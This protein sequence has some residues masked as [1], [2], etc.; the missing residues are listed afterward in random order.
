MTLQNF[1]QIFNEPTLPILRWFGNSVLVA[2]VGT[3]A[4]LALSSLS[5]YAFARLQFPGRSAIFST[6]IAS[7]MIPGAVTLIPVFIMLRD[8]RL[9]DS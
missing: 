8:L 1:R 5:G 3:V 7:L 2:T 4:V 6:L 9:L